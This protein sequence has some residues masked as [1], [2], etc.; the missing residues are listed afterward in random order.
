VGI[1]VAATR[2]RMP[3]CAVLIVSVLVPSTLAT[4]YADGAVFVA[5]LKL[6]GRF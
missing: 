4:A 3:V 2:E 5:L 1:L 6:G